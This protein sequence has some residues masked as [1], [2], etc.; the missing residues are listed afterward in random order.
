MRKKNRIRFYVVS[1]ICAVAVIVLSAAPLFNE[2]SDATLLTLMFVCVGTGVLLSNMI[3][4]LKRK[5]DDK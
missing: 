2:Q 1:L 3:H 4:D 5:R